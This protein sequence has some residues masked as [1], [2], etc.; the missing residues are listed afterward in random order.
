MK[1]IYTLGEFNEIEITGND[2]EW[3]AFALCLEQ[4]T[5]EIDCETTDDPSP[6]SNCT[7]RSA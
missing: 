3:T 7:T 5:F 4:R 1:A 6:Y 2:V